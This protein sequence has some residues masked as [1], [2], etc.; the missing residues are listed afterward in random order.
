MDLSA[1]LDLFVTEAREHI[2]SAAALAA[3]DAPREA[4]DAP[5]REL[6][7]HVHSVK[8]MAAS[9][10]YSAMSALAHDAE[11]LMDLVR[12]GRIMP[13]PKTRRI[14]CDAWPA[15][16]AWSIGPRRNS[17]WTTRNAARFRRVSEACC[18]ARPIRA[19]G[20]ARRSGRKRA[21]AGSE[22]PPGRRMRQA[23][24]SS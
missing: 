4:G 9:M 22:A 15:S 2:G 5:L 1:Y 19:G 20:T 3:G 7:R 11:S 21:P 10:G 23:R 17:R 12:Q 8:G 13:K 16:S 24:R 18:A 6:F 14:L